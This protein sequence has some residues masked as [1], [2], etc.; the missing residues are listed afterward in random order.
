MSA[1]ND[2]IDVLT[3]SENCEDP[4]IKEVIATTIFNLKKKFGET[5]ITLATINLVIKD[6]MEL[7]EHFSCPGKEKKKHVVNIV[8]A[9]IIDLVEDVEE[10]RILLEFIDKNILE[11][12]IDL[13][14]S[15]TKGEF[16][17]NNKKTQKKVASCTK[18]L[19]PIIIDTIMLIINASKSAKTK[20]VSKA[21]A[22]KAAAKTAAKTT[23]KA[24]TKKKTKNTV[25]VIVQPEN[26]ETQE[27]QI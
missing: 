5:K 13:I 15:A 8:K 26:S 12:T 18:S 6:T 27:E 25:T 7:V 9:L 24:A 20:V 4:Q 19:I 21:K 14:I 17:F 3:L 10:E 16:N 23:A 2:Q 11:S 1:T 22:A